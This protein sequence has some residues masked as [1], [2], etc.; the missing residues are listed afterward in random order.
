MNKAAKLKYGTLPTLKEQL[1]RAKTKEAD[2][3]ANSNKDVKPMLRDEVVPDDIANIISVW[4][5]IPSAKLLDT[6]RDRVLNMADKLRERV[7][8]QDEAIEIVTD[9]I[10][11]SRAGMNDPTKPISSPG[12]RRCRTTSTSP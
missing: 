12:G 8:G 9:A 11:R 3:S 1:E 4:T 7:V 2:G 5:G 10:Q 6:E